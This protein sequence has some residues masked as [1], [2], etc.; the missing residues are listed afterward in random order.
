M[1]FSSVYGIK[2]EANVNESF[3]LIHY[4]YSKFKVRE[5]ILYKLNQKNLFVQA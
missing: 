5:E 1:P 4:S 3:N 2:N